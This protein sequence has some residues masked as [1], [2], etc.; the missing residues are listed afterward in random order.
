[1]IAKFNAAADAH[2]ERFLPGLAATLEREG[3]LYLARPHRAFFPTR[4]IL[5]FHGGGLVF[6]NGPSVGYDAALEAVRLEVPVYG[7]DFRQPPDFPFPAARD[8]ALAAYTQLLDRYSPSDICF[9]AISGGANPAVSALYTARDRGLP[10]PAGLFLKSPMIDLTESGESFIVNADDPALPGG[11]K[12]AGLLYA[13]GAPLDD[14]AVSPLFG[15]PFGFPPVLL[16]TGEF[17]VMQS[18]AT[19]FHEK[20][21][22]RGVSSTLDIVPKSP[23]GGFGGGTHEDHVAHTAMKRFLVSLW[24]YP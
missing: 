21:L 22:A 18:N 15:D 14:P 16:Q 5:Y 6:F 7:L 11:M 17:D 24:G 1:M 23:H 8:D 4:A 19:R 13:A 9:S 2:A 3:F 12:E 10:M 20:L